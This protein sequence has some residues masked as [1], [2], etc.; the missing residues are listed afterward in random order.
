MQTSTL[1]YFFKLFGITGWSASF[2]WAKTSLLYA[3]NKTKPNNLN[4]NTNKTMLSI[5]TWKLSKICCI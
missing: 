4:T 3:Y 1:I 2:L 5:Y